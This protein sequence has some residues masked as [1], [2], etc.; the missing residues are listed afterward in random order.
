MALF[1]P[2]EFI[3]H[4]IPYFPV[5]HGG[6]GQHRQERWLHSDVTFCDLALRWFLGSAGVDPKIRNVS[7]DG[8]T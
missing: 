2:H 3:T 7:A 4:A 8:F 5:G 1:D 6:H